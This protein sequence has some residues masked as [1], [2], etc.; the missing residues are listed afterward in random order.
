[1]RAYGVRWPVVLLSAAVTLLL[2]FGAQLLYARQT[3]AQPLNA[4]LRSTPGVMGQ[5]V[6][7]SDGLGLAVHVRLGLVP[8]LET[9]YL[10]LLHAADHAAGG[11]Q[12]IL[13]VKDNASQQ[14][15]DDYIALTTILDQGRAT[16]QYVAMRDQFQA[17]ATRMHLTSADL[18]LDGQQMYVELVSGKNYLY[19]ILP[20]VLSPATSKAS[21]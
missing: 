19:R 5:P 15:I 9:T 14:L 7:A 12:V 13:T 8:D 4:A 2:L 18:T 6:V 20:L 10:Q 3:F 11:R 16:G 1:M 21:S 17:A